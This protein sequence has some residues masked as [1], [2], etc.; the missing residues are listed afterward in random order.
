M[1]LDSRHASATTPNGKQTFSASLRFELVDEEQRALLGSYAIA[2][3][4]GLGFLL[5]IQFGPRP[6][7]LPFAEQGERIVVG[8]LNLPVPTPVRERM[9][10]EAAA[11]S[12]SARGSAVRPAAGSIAGAFEATGTGPVVDAGNLLGNVA[13]TRG[14]AGN[15]VGTAGKTVLGYGA[16]GSGS[17]APTRGGISGGGGGS[18]G[19]V[20]TR[21]SVSRSGAPVEALA[22]VPVAPL[23]VVGDVGSVGTVVRAHESQLRFCYQ[24]SGLKADP[25]LAGSITV[26]LTVGANGDVRNASVTRRTWSGAGAA[27]AE[28]CILR[29]V[30]AWRLPGSGT[31]SATYSFPF[32]F[33]R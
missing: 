17:A 13:V 14:G 25:A 4:I 10:R 2:S 9:E 24:E 1:A 19:N 3:A 27:G 20:A 30:R 23:P 6:V 8:D 12:G 28:A 11:A 5:L 7:V 21:G 31:G 33:S 32:N 18:I 16:R 15:D 22:V 26:A 29:V